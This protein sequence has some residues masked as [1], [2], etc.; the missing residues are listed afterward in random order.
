MIQNKEQL[1]R[2]FEIEER[3]SEGDLTVEQMSVYEQEQK[4]I[5]IDQYYIYR[6]FVINKLKE[7]EEKYGEI[8]SHTFFEC[9]MMIKIDEEID[10]W[11]DSNL[12]IYNAAE[13][14]DGRWSKPRFELSKLYDLDV[15]LTFEEIF[16]L[17]VTEHKVNRWLIGE[18]YDYKKELIVQRKK[19]EKLEN[20]VE[21]SDKLSI[22]LQLKDE[23]WDIDYSYSDKPIN[24]YDE[25]K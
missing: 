18:S 14:D 4:S 20:I 8:C 22:D 17:E 11:T 21:N 19:L 15:R 5:I 6:N 3:L 10:L 25:I 13:Y 1:R 2:I 7:Y 23:F 24:Y 16:D 9:A 12:Y